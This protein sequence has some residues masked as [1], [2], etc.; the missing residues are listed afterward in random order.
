MAAKTANTAGITVLAASGNDGLCDSI[1]IPSCLFDVISVGAVYD[2]DIGEDE[3]CV[4]L[5]S[6][7][8]N[9][10]I[11][12]E[13]DTLLFVNE[14]RFTDKVAAYSNTALI[15]DILAPAE[16]AHTTDI[17]GPGGEEPGDY[18]RDFSGTSA[19]CP[20]AAGAVAV[21]QSA[22]KEL[23]GEFLS[24]QRIREILVTTGEPI[25]DPKG[26]NIK[27]RINLTAAIDTLIENVGRFVPRTVTGGGGQAVAPSVHW[28]ASRLMGVTHAR[29]VAAN[30]SVL[31]GSLVL[32]QA[33]QTDTTHWTVY[34]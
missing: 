10:A 27:P 15:L 12:V 1:S 14:D 6:C 3:V 32:G 33:S 30:G 26:D 31:Q 24:P 23:T 19:A 25:Y 2:D 18:W 21:L 7:L 16:N 34:E 11:G 5:D 8:R 28:M 4:K 9:K 13:C 29:S 20:Y 22:A 17:I